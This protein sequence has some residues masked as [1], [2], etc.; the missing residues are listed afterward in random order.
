MCESS[1]IDNTCNR[2]HSVKQKLNVSY[3][4]YVYVH[5]PKYMLKWVQSVEF[6][7]QNIVDVPRTLFDMQDKLL[8]GGRRIWLDM[9][10][11]APEWCGPGWGHLFPKKQ[12]S[13]RRDPFSSSKIIAVAAINLVDETGCSAI[14]VRRRLLHAQIRLLAEFKFKNCNVNIK[15][16]L[17]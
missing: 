1:F 3:E 16:G 12:H 17:A 4:S 15:L 7:V 6:F 5:R 14:I 10:R 9:S 8:R 13:S 2:V 11:W